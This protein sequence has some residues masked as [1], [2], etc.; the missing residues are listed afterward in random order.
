MI[1]ALAFYMFAC[2]AV[3]AAVLV[4]SAKN[5]VHSVL[6]LILTFFNAA[7]LFVLLGA[8]FL[9]MI[10]VVVYVGAVAVLFMF[11]VMMLDIN[12]VELRQ[13]FLQYLPIGGLIGIVLLVELLVLV[14]GWTIT[15]DAARSAVAKAPAPEVT[16]NTH[17]LG[18]IIYTQYIY[19]FQA[20][21]LVLLVAMIGAIVLTHRHRDSVKKQNI[22]DQ[23]ARR[24]EEAVELQK[25]D[26]GKGI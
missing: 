1:E 16:S 25:V 3:A 23:L 20:A 8:E 9:A 6:F 5:P 13:G 22:G 12:F 21:G 10:L 14:G 24:A 26:I 18:E 19:L 4:I 11:V 2:T 7:G 17:A 15:A